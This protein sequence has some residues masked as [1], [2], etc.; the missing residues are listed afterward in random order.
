MNV[1]PAKVVKVSKRNFQAQKIFVEKLQSDR[2]SS[3]IEQDLLLH[4]SSYGTVI[5]VKVLKNGPLNRCRSVLRL[6]HF[7]GG[8]SGLRGARPEAGDPRQRSSPYQ[9]LV[10]RA[11]EKLVKKM[12]QKAAKRATKIFVGGI[13]NKATKEELFALFSKY[14]A[15]E[16]LSLPYKS[17][18]ENKGYAFVTYQQPEAVACVFSD[19]KNIILRAKTVP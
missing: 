16:D 10:S 17:K 11:L 15:I 5:D 9:V 19:L 3:Q 14:G 7:F 6:R 1:F 13:P 2:N 4:F 8:R 12:S 18:L